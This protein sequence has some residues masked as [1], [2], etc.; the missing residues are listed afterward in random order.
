MERLLQY[1]VLPPQRST[2]LPPGPPGPADLVPPPPSGDHASPAAS[3]LEDLAG[4]KEP[5]LEKHGTARQERQQIWHRAEGGGAS[6]AAAADPGPGWVQQGHVVFSNVWLWYTPA[7][8]DVLRGLS[9]DV[10]PGTKLGIVGR[11]G[12]RRGQGPAAAP[13]ERCADLQW[14][15]A[16]CRAGQWRAG[17]SA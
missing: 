13:Q 16:G 8:P 1:M 2:V 12:G 17:A 9:L 14:R 10:P 15:R 4:L 5:L 3:A 6:A 7:G 11:T